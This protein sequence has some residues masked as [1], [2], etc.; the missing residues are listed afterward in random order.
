MPARWPSHMARATRSTMSTGQP[1]AP[2]LGL[3]DLQGQAA[4]A[5][6]RGEPLAILLRD[7][8]SLT[9]DLNRDVDHALAKA[10]G[11]DD[12][13]HVGLA[14]PADGAQHRPIERAEPL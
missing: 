8:P 9:E 14:E 1:I 6:V 2:L 5:Q 7:Q 3:V 11:V 10:G 13:G 4:L 12:A